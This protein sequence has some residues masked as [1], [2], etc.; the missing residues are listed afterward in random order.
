[1]DEFRLKDSIPN[2]VLCRVKKRP[3]QK[4]SMISEDVNHDEGA[5]ICVM[6]IKVEML[7]AT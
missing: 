5:I 6:K 1:M 3:Q 2:I 7:I 4:F